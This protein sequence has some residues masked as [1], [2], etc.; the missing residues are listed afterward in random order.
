MTEETTI[1]Q[2]QGV[3]PQ[4]SSIFGV[5]LRGLLAGVLVVTVCISHLMVVCAAMWEA[6]YAKDWARVGTF[7]T[8]GE[9]LY[10]MSIAA[11]GFYFG[12]KVT[13]P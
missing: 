2:K 11:L 4:D 1:I 8:V 10:S 3:S 7:T 6:L 5:S 12:Q 9:P 13:K